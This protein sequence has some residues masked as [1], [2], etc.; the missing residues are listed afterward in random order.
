MDDIV[1]INSLNKGIDEVADT[2]RGTNHSI[3][4]SEQASMIDQQH[5]A[6]IENDIDEA[7]WEEIET[8]TRQQAHL[9]VNYMTLMAIG[10]A[11][12]T[13]GLVSEP[14][15]Q[16]VALVAA[17]VIAPGFEPLTAVPLGLVVRNS[18][19]VWRGMRSALVGYAVLMLAA[20]L[21]FALLRWMG[22]TS[23]MDSS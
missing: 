23:E 19:T 2:C 14:G 13:V 18:H 22:V 17:S 11:I 1:V 9:T 10:G 12:A 4:T 8:D 3:A 15:P 6:I 21:T 7:I 20:A 16:A 5:D